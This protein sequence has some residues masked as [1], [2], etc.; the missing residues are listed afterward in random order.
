MAARAPSHA[1]TTAFEKGKR[2]S[3]VRRPTLTLPKPVDKAQDAPSLSRCRER[4]GVG[5][6]VRV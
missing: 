6:W 5:G 2:K 4:E 3:E 1:F